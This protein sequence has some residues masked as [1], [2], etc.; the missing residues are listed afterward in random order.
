MEG[1]EDLVSRV[2]SNNGRENG[3]YY[4]VY[5]VLGLG[6]GGLSK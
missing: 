4:R 6:S 5:R 1:Q 3:N 2:Y